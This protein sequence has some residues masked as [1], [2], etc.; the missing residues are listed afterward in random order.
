MIEEVSFIV[1]KT[2]PSIGALLTVCCL[3][4]DLLPLVISSIR[5]FPIVFKLA[6]ISPNLKTLSSDLHISFL[7][8]L[9][10][11]TFTAKLLKGVFSTCY[12][13]F[14]SFHELFSPLQ[15]LYSEPNKALL[16]NLLMSI[17]LGN[18]AACFFQPSCQTSWQHLT[19]T[20]YQNSLLSWLPGRCS[21]LVFLLFLWLLFLSLLCWL[22]LLDPGPS[23]LSIV[24]SP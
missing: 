7:L 19:P 18:M 13:Y 11:A 4:K 23:A 3:L 16:L 2:S 9:F 10:S 21:L 15:P 17:R 24:F 8:L 22:F 12:I 1:S 20:S 6:V 14:F 5:A